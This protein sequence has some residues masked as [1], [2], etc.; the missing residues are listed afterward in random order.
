MAA[1]SLLIL[2]GVIAAA[3][4]LAVMLYQKNGQ[5]GNLHDEEG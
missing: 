3:V 4:A 1:G 2:S 5:H